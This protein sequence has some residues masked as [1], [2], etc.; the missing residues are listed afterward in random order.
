MCSVRTH[1]IN[2]CSKQT[3]LKL[4]LDKRY[5]TSEIMSV[6]SRLCWSTKYIFRDCSVATDISQCII[7]IIIKYVDLSNNGT[8]ARGVKVKGRRFKE[9]Q[10][11]SGSKCT[12]LFKRKMNWSRFHIEYNLYNVTRLSLYYFAH[13]H[14]TCI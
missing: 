11:L 6:L 4:L 12:P 7:V 8:T 10:L 2:V 9:I 3:I 13:I 5:F 1:K 14:H